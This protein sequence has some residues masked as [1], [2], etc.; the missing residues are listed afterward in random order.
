MTGDFHLRIADVSISFTWDSLT[1]PEEFDPHYQSFC[2]SSGNGQKPIPVR[3]QP[4]LPESLDIG[5]LERIYAS[6]QTWSLF[7]KQTDYFLVL[8]PP[9][10]KEDPLC[11]ARFRRPIEDVEIFCNPKVF[12]MRNGRRFIP[13]PWS[14]PMDR[15][16][17]SYFLA[18]REGTLMHAAGIDIEGKGYIFPGKSGNWKT[19]LSRRFVSAE[20]PVV[21]SD[22]RV[23]VR[24]VNGEFKA[25]GT[26]WPG[27]AEI[28]MNRGLPLSGI[29]FIHHGA[30]NRISEIDSGEAVK[31]LLSLATIPWYDPEMMTRALLFCEDLLSHVPC[32]DFHFTPDGVVNVMKEF[33]SHA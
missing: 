19:T 8:D 15:L 24:K 22:E 33:A 10:F 5:K 20:G 30:R 9:K 16:L 14:Y 23:A 29:F 18:E 7:R 3:I 25:F 17:T 31:R 27:D 4:Q 1:A 21:L 11:V 26:P 6:G 12:R 13:N 28:A 2:A 32:Y